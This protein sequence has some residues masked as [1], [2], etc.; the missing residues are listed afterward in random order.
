MCDWD[1]ET[2]FVIDE[3]VSWVDHQGATWAGYAYKLAVDKP[4]EEREQEDD[5][6]PPKKKKCKKKGKCASNAGRRATSH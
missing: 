1:G 6:E 2:S 5:G 3:A 4:T